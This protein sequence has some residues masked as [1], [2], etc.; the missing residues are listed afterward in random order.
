MIDKLDNKIIDAANKVNY[1]YE[2]PKNRYIEIIKEKIPWCISRER[3][4]GT[5]LPI[6]S[7]RHRSGKKG[8]FSRKEIIE[9]VLIYLTEKILNYIDH[10]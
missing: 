9:Q 5:P 2:H 8:L 10:G 1:F 3:I 7:C 6:W 4:W